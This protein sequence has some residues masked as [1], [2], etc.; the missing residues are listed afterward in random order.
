M[1]YI[2]NKLFAESEVYRAGSMIE[3]NTNHVQAKE[4]H[5]LIQIPVLG[6]LKGVELTRRDPTLGVRVSAPPM[7]H[8]FD[9]S[10]PKLKW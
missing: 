10:G 2:K 6:D 1:L 5:G 7:K 3:M 4:A 8:L 9:I